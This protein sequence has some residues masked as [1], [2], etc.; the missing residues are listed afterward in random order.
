[1]RL[2]VWGVQ[3]VSYAREFEL[4]PVGNKEPMYIV[5]IIII[6]MLKYA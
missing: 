5:K 3:S 4:D 6:I 2:Q 1:M